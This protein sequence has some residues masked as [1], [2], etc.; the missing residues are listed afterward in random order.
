V[1]D[2]QHAM[3]AGNE[4]VYRPDPARARLYD[5]AYRDYLKL[6]GFVERELTRA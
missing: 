5:A 1:E 2:A 6:G 4:A 3:S